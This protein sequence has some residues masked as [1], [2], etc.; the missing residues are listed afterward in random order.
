MKTNQVQAKKSL[1]VGAS[2]ISE[3]HKK[4]TSTGTTFRANRRGGIW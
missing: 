1:E 4:T 3:I 2:R